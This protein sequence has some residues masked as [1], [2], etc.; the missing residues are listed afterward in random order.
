MR[1][2]LDTPNPAIPQDQLDKMDTNNTLALQKAIN[3]TGVNT[4]LLVESSTQTNVTGATYTIYN[5]ME[6]VVTSSGGFFDITYKTVVGV[7][8]ANTLSAQLLI[9]GAVKDFT[10]M[11]STAN[12]QFGLYL[13]YRG[14][15]GAGRHNIAVKISMNG[16]T[17]HLQENSTQGR[18]QAVET[19]L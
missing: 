17:F 19:V 8:S 9:D 6:G 13:Q 3:K 11:G 15:L 12:G 16:G 7:T 14:A 1:V 2:Q 10:Q 4:G 5:G 18:L